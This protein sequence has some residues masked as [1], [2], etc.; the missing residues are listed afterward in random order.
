MW[1]RTRPRGTEWRIALVAISVTTVSVVVAALAMTRS[2]Y[3][4]G[5]PLASIRETSVT[6]HARPGKPMTWGTVLPENSTRSDIVIESIEPSAPVTGLTILGIGVSDPRSGA[7]GTAEGYPPPGITP[8]EVA[9]ALITPRS[10]SSPFLQV[11]IGVRLDHPPGGRVAGLRIRYATAGHRY[12][13]VLSD[14]LLVI[15]PER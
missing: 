14:A 10:G 13:M 4:A 8:H 15:P 11:V 5:G 2:G 12:E 3:E 1:V 6:T 7:V 9:G